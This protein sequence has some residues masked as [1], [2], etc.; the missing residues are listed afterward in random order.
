MNAQ[1]I[2]TIRKIR[3][4]CDEF[5]H[6]K[7]DFKLLQSTLEAFHSNF[8]NDI[9]KELQNYVGDFIGGLESIRWMHEEEDYFKLVSKEIEKLNEFLAKYEHNDIKQF[10]KE[11]K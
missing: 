1:T 11:A 10:S 3:Q 2:V 8:E 6:Q 7:I 4:I 5:L 9:P